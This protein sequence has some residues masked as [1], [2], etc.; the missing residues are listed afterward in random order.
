[1]SWSPE[2]YLK[3]AQPRLRPAIDLLDRI[4]L[5][6]PKEICDLGCGAG[7]VTAILAARWPGARISGVDTSAAMLARAAQALP[8]VTWQQQSLGEWRAPIARWI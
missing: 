4:V 7:N 1:M 3:F 8:Q 5:E 6:Q 2:Q